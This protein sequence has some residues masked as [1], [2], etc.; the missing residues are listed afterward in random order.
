MPTSLR[1]SASAPP[2][3]YPLSLHDALPICRRL[4]RFGQRVGTARGVVGED[5]GVL[6]RR[7]DAVLLGDPHRGMG[8][9]LPERPGG[10]LHPGVGPL[11]RSEEHRSALQAVRRLVCPH[12]CVIAHRRRP[13]STLFP[14]T[15]LFRSAGDLS[16]SAS[17]SGLPGGSSARTVEFWA[18]GGTPCCSGTPTVGWGGFSLSAPGGTSI[19]VSDP[20]DDRKSTGLH[21]RQFDV[22]Y[23]HIAAL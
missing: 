19:Q 16:V 5:R 10:D 7:G 3:V 15:T 1:Y 21:Y 22:S 11:G 2:R 4:V 14:Y 8:R 6:G 20:S 12:R 23:A 9:V 13:G 17:A 18:G